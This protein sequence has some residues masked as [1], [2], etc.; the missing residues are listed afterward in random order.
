MSPPENLST[1]ETANPCYNPPFDATDP[2][3]LQPGEGERMSTPTE[4]ELRDRFRDAGQGHLIDHLESLSGEAREGFAE[5]LAGIDLD[6]V[7]ARRAQYEGEQTAEAIHAELQP[8]PVIRLPETDEDRRARDAARAA[9]EDALR[10]GR[11]AAFV[12]AGG[13]GTRL[14]FDGPKGAFPFGPVT[15]RTLFRIHA[16]QILARADR[17]G[18]AIPWYVMTSDANDQATREAFAADGYFGMRPEDVMFFRQ[19]MVPAMDFAGKLILEAP[20]RLA[21]SPN[22][23]GGSLFALARSGATADMKRRGI[24]TIS[25]FQVD[26]PLVTICDP[27]FAGHHIQ[28]DAEMSSKVLEKNCP[29]EKVGV[30]CYRDGKLSVV[31]YSDLDEKNMYARDDAGRLKYW[32]GSIAIHMLDVDFVDRVGSGAGQLP[33]HTAIKKV[34]CLDESGETVKPDEPNGVKFETFVFDALPLA[35]GSVTLEVA[36]ENEFAPV[37][38]PTGVDSVESARALMSD[39]AARLLE[40]AGVT[41]PRDADGAPKAAIELSYRFA[42]DAEQLR[43]KI[44]P[45]MKVDE[46][47]ILE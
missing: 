39:Y 22:G 36:R 46:T 11:L 30:V 33:W 45:E 18:V 40:A 47:L 3:R 31:E 12:V 8:A 37:K 5:A 19:E 38:N 16:E 23:H 34:P 10:A 14:G 2:L 28:A 15:G 27:V 29:E 25:Y 44:D 20:G 1:G 9:G 4:Q 26:N 6:W 21:M 24:D 32:A 35:D 43:A 13:Q 7:A 41:V 42:L 17:Y